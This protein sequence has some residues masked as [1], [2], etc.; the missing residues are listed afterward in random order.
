MKRYLH[1][2]LVVL[3][4]AC[5]S[6]KKTQEAL[7]SGDYDNAIAIAV[8]KLRDNKTKKGNQPYVHM[9][10]E[11]FAKAVERDQ[12][13]ISF[14]KKDGN[15]ANLET[16]YE[17]YNKLNRRQEMVKPLLPLPILDKNK[18]AKFKF[19]DYSNDIIAVKGQLSEYLYANASAVLK[20]SNNKTDFRNA[21][22]DFAYLNKINPNYKDVASK[23]E[24]AHF[25]GTDF[26][27]VSMFND[28]EMVI[29]RRLEDELLNFNTYGINDFWTV[30]HSNPQK[31]IKYDYEMELAF[32]DI[33]ISPEQIKEKQII[34]EKEVKDGWKYLTDGNG[35][36]VKDSLGNDIKVD[37][38]VTVRCTFYEFTQFKAVNVAGVVAFTDLNSNQTVNSYPLASEYVFQHQYANYKGDRR[39]LDNS[40]LRLLDERSVPFPSNEQMV[41]DAGE[42]VKQRL[43]GI[44]TK[45]RF[46]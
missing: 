14:L 3:I 10:E 38:F 43:K 7:N 9:L 35:N 40:F 15:P 23:M 45:H 34:K 12:Q 31:E 41:Y 30:Y 2:L 16:I 42:D 11:A 39:A 46:N 19:S 21:Y 5:S 22:D 1:L 4:V 17:T 29:P 6:V 27:K 33:K 28:N 13:E 36:R 20:K 18:N 37:R 44:L 24:E 8:D 25:K 32:K 26:V